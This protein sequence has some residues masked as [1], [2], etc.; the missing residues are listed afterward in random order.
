MCE[1]LTVSSWLALRTAQRIRCSAAIQISIPAANGCLEHA[2][3]SGLESVDVKGEAQD[4]KPGI[5]HSLCNV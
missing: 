3:A 2:T 5:Q 4:A 1:E